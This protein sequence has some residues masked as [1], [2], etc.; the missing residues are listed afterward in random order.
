MAFLPPTGGGGI[1]GGGGGFLPTFDPTAAP[2]P[3]KKK[4]FWDPRDWIVRIASPFALPLWAADEL[5]P[6]FLDPV[7]NVPRGILSSPLSAALHP[8]AT[9]RGGYNV[10]RGLG[11]IPTLLE[12]FI[13]EP[14][15]TASMVGESIW[16]DYKRRYGG[17][18]DKEI[19]QDP[20]SFLF[21]ALAITAPAV[22][23]GALASAAARL[24]KANLALGGSKVPW[25]TNVWKEMAE[26]GKISTGRWM[27]GEFEEGEAF[28]NVLGYTP[29]TGRERLETTFPMSRSPFRR[30]VQQVNIA[31]SEAMPGLPGIG[32]ESRYWRNRARNEERLRQRLLGKPE[33]IES[34]DRLTD[35]G[36]TRLYWGA[37][38]GVHTDE[39]LQQFRDVMERELKNPESGLGE[40]DEDLGD[41]VPGLTT[42]DVKGILREAKKAGLGKEMLDGLDEALKFDITPGT[43]NRK[44]YDQG[45]RALQDMTELIEAT[46]ADAHGFKSLA[47]DLQR[48]KDRLEGL[49]R[50]SGEWEEQANLVDKLDSDVRQKA[51]SLA[52]IFDSRRNIVRDFWRAKHRVNTPERAEWNALLHE[53]FGSQTARVF[54]QFLDAFAGGGKDPT[55]RWRDL[56]GMPTGE[57]STELLGRL[58]E[59]AGQ[60]LYQG[61]P[62]SLR[63][64]VSPERAAQNRRYIEG[65]DLHKPEMG[66]H[67][68]AKNV[69]MINGERIPI[70]GPL[71]PAEWVRRAETV[72]PDRE[73]RNALAHWYEH[74]PATFYRFLGD[75]AEEILRAWATSQA[76]DSPTGGLEATMRVLD[77]LRRGDEV[78][79][80]E[81]SLVATNIAKAADGG[82]VTSGMA[83]KLHDFADAIEGK[84]TRTW[85]DDDPKGGAP[86]PND[87]HA[88]RDAGFVDPKLFNSLVNP[89]PNA[90]YRK[91][92]DPEKI[93]VD[94]SGRP[95]D[96]QYERI[97]E[98]YQDVTNHLNEIEFDGRSNWK[99]AQVQALGWSVIQTLHGV[100]PETAEMAF[101][102]NIRRVSLEVTQGISSIGADLSFQ[103]STL[104]A[105][106]VQG[107]VED[108]VAEEDA[109]W[110]MS[111]IKTGISAYEG[112]PNANLNFDL[113]GSPE[114]VQKIV[115]R[116][117]GAF[118][119]WDVW[120]TKPSLTG[121]GAKPTLRIYGD[122]LKDPRKMHDLYQEL[123]RVDAKRFPGFAPIEGADGVPGIALIL[124]RGKAITEAAIKE[125]EAE[126]RP[127]V[128][129]AS[130]AA[131]MGDETI[132]LRAGNTRII[133]RGETDAGDLGGAGGGPG[134]ERVLDDPL[135]SQARQRLEQA[136]DEV[137]AARAEGRAPQAFFQPGLGR[138]AHELGYIEDMPPPRGAVELL[139][140]WRQRMHLLEDAD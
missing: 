70:F 131:G 21:D 65:G 33:N 46:I 59:E 58:A 6:S 95:V 60:A 120:A 78:T 64:S 32:A 127:M 63:R 119:Q 87:V 52:Q 76:N 99:P 101:R 9:A 42:A 90:L 28:R 36:R 5:S 124:G 122:V 34:L 13:E 123:Y 41:E 135:A 48:A 79:N 37:Q 55:Q 40:L 69:R 67:Q 23:A 15:E 138:A 103:E 31:L 136:V 19:A 30:G 26:P 39:A 54:M 82:E 125:A 133:G 8:G 96:H 18:L 104:V 12:A 24:G 75:D 85:M 128:E 50:G 74:V 109:L 102:N 114:K 7:F 80:D 94:S 84:A 57:S 2:P 1:P 92:F 66:R 43:K 105:R 112:T 111:P 88:S 121:K 3:R 139:G 17:D 62:F 44:L 20:L 11:E 100:V 86:T 110:L 93:K 129:E 22:R 72:I 113:L 107:I 132:R 91:G 73:N 68:N 47:N 115:T 51:D 53:R 137:R 10:I 45:L 61:A 116:L 16:E 140:Q 81:I 71:T 134:R 56:I 89:R 97:R 117:A 35:A 27:D 98:F 118:D 4:S 130:R 29:A 83:A 106:A 126:L 38:L 25:K 14:T 108:M 49:E 77:K